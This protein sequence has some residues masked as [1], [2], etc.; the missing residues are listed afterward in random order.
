MRNISYCRVPRG[1]PKEIV[2]FAKLGSIGVSFSEDSPLE[3]ILA[4]ILCPT[5]A[6]MAKLVDKYIGILFHARDQLD[7]GVPIN[8]LL[9]RT[10]AQCEEPFV[11]SESDASSVSDISPLDFSG[12]LSDFVD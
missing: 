12:D 1:L 3:H 4:K 2:F 8:F 5:S 7:Q 10:E 6:K 11:D 9:N